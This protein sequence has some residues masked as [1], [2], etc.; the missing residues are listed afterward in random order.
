M[1]EIQSAPQ[2]ISMQ[3]PGFRAGLRAL[4]DGYR[5]LFRTPDIWPSAIIPVVVAL[6]LMGLFGVVAVKTA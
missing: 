5:Y 3:R 4:F 1:N 6:V 2:V